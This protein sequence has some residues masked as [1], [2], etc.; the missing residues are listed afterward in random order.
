MLQ[1]Y[2]VRAVNSRCKYR[3]AYIFYQTVCAQVIIGQQ[4]EIEN[5]FK[6]WVDGNIP[7][8]DFVIFSHTWG[9][10]VPS[11][12]QPRYK[13]ANATAIK[14]RMTET[15]P[16][17]FAPKTLSQQQQNWKA[18]INKF[19]WKMRDFAPMTTVLWMNSFQEGFKVLSSS[20]CFTLTQILIFIPRK[21]APFILFRYR[22]VNSN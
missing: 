21:L 6:L 12:F 7:N 14:F 18:I 3:A 5:G 1:L 19:F 13:E 20:I 17:I 10:R 4:L 22:S 15:T 16:K 11:E 2:I 8:Q 9:T